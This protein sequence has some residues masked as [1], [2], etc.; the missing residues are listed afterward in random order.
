MTKFRV[1]PSQ[2][3]NW[4]YIF[5]ELLSERAVGEQDVVKAVI[6]S[7]LRLLGE[8]GASKTNIWLIEYNTGKGI[9]R[10]SHKALQ[11]VVAAIT[12][13]TRIGESTAAFNVLG[14]SG[15]IKKGREKWLKPKP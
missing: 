4:R 10:C 13:I 15:T 2:K 9:L 12:T 5:F 1:K 11:N 6:N 7:I 3:A 14:V 8:L